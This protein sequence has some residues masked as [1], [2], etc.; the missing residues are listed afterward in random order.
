MCTSF[1]RPIR[2]VGVAYVPTRADKMRVLADAVDF[3]EVTPE[4]FCD[5]HPRGEA[6]PPRLSLNRGETEFALS[7]VAPR[8]FT[9]HGT[10]LSIGSPGGFN[11]AYLAML[12][13]LA[14]VQRFAWHSAPL[15]FSWIDGHHLGAQLPLPRTREAADLVSVR[16][17]EIKDRVG[18]PFLFENTTHFLPDVPSE[19]PWDEVTFLNEVAIASDCGLLI[20]MD[21][22]EDACRLRGD[23]PDEALERLDLLRVEQ[24]HVRPDA[25]RTDAQW[26][27][28][29]RI[30][31]R[32]PYLRGVVMVPGHDD[33][34]PQRLPACQRELARL[35][36][37]TSVTKQ[38]IC[39]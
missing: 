18:R 10:G 13:E 5:E 3:F 33:L 39:A 16:A 35:R 31:R 26:R 37:L 17:R 20:D 25:E 36:E 24:L 7:I 2:G 30:V 29:G 14:D 12:E 27:R 23:D 28:L 15:S 1:G 32:A 6:R 38:E 9:V 19:Q 22:L 11:D 21:A 8:P 4:A 34:D